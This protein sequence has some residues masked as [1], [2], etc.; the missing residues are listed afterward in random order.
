MVYTVGYGNALR[1]IGQNLIMKHSL[2]ELII[3]RR[4][5]TIT[6]QLDYVF[7]HI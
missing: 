7:L 2:T 4:P 5:N 1:V 3:K 6:L